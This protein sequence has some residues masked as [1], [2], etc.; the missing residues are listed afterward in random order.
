MSVELKEHQ[1][2][3]HQMVVDFAH[4]EIEPLDTIIDKQKGY[5]KQ[6]WTKIVETGFL[7][8]ITP[9]EFGGG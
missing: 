9:T 7:G 4:K 3:L 8:L 5:P 6:L 2:M 1:Q